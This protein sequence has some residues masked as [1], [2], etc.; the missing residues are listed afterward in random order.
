MYRVRWVNRYAV[1]NTES[2]RLDI[3]LPFGELEVEP[4]EAV[5]QTLL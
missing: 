1:F 5:A 4:K 2:K 3:Y